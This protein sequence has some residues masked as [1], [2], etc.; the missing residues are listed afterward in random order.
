[1]KYMH[2]EDVRPGMILAEDIYLSRNRAIPY[3]RKDT[4]LTTHNITALRTSGID[5]VRITERMEFRP[6][7]KDPTQGHILRPKA[8]V[9]PK[10]KTTALDNLKDIFTL[11]VQGEESGLSAPQL[12][13]QLDSVVDQLVD[14]VLR[15]RSALVNIEGLRSYDEYTYHHSLSVAVLSIATGQALGMSAR[16][17]KALGKCAL[18][19]DIGKTSVPIEI[20]NKPTRLSADEYE[21]VKSHSPAGFSYL[22]QS[23]IGN[24]ALLRGV[25]FHHEKVDGTGYPKQL[26][27]G[28]IPIWSRIIAVAD[29]YDA[30]TS[31]RPY[32]DP[33]H[34]AA[35]VEYVMAGVETAF[36][37]D[38]V[39]GFLG[40]L[41]LYPVGSR[42][43]LTG[44]LEA[45][46][47]N[48]E[49]TM[50]PL[51]RL[52]ETDE[53]LDLYADLSCLNLTIEKILS[54][55]TIKAV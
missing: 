48:C 8:I 12:V 50:R 22:Y 20:I 38:V 23:N 13:R 55:D 7:G 45:V 27:G 53:V 52:T 10:L 18:M 25:L 21:L 24:D 33:M 36:D 31:H 47:I 14:S 4:M 29:V 32:R 3:V 26:K 16:E 28:Q 19:H 40:K 5:F 46:V 44:G 17:L 41:E 42:V 15:D 37:Y 43:L 2:I 9:T 51:V 6:R 35:A 54:D 1:M 34:P 30:L 49:N 39:K 11:A